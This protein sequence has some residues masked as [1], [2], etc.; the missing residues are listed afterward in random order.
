[1]ITKVWFVGLQTAPV[2][3]WFAL[4]V[5]RRRREWLENNP[6]VRRRHA[7]A[8]RVREGLQRLREQAANQDAE[9]FFATLFRLLQEQLGERLDQSAPSITTDVI[10]DRLRPIGV[11]E[12]TLVTLRELFDACDQARFAPQRSAGELGSFIPKTESVL[13]ALQEVQA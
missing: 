7:V 2:W 11:P 6:R 9:A 1:L 10:E 8:A 5:R 12:D 13:R 4:L 3:A